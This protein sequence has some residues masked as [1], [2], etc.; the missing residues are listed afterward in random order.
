MVLPL[1]NVL[2]FAQIDEDEK[3]EYQKKDNEN[4]MTVVLFED[5]PQLLL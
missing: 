2:N 4:K 3:E 5:I 1:L